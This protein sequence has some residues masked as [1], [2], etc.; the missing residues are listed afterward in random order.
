VEPSAHAHGVDDF[1]ADAKAAKRRADVAVVVAKADVAGDARP[2][3]VQV[4]WISERL[5]GRPSSL[6]GLVDL[7]GGLA[8]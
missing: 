7:G 1:D 2:A 5:S 3:H 6:G 4:R 8:A